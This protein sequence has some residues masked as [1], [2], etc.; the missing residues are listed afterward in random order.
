MKHLI[1]KYKLHLNSRKFLLSVFFAVVLFAIS[2]AAN[3]YA[4]LYATERASNSVTDI[5]LSNVR[6]FD[7]DGLF[8]YGTIAF[9]A[10][11]II[12]FLLRPEKIP[13]TLKTIALFVFVRSVF[14]S[15]T[16]IG[17]YP[18]QI[19]IDSNILSAFVFGGDL[20]FS[21][22]TGLPFLMA[23][24]FWQDVYLRFLF[25]ASS[26]IFG[27]VVLLA[28]LHYS[29]DVL[30]AFFI[31]YTIYHIAEFIFKKDREVFFS[32]VKP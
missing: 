18:T 16:H 8:V 30:S 13:F 19:A 15:L 12:L 2:L 9:W 17:P 26:I 4:G 14:V 11:V 25:I 32:G 29:I 7:V 21:G 24:I 3:F 28:H 23:L 22:H 5:V 20:F 31:T 6:A 10:F 1:N 27:I